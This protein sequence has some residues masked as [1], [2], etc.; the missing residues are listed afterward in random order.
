[1]IME[2][3]IVKQFSAF[4]EDWVPKEAS[5]AVAGGDKYISYV[6]GM[7]DIHIHHGQSIPS[8]SITEQVYASK[9]RIESLVDK[10]VF[11]LPYYGVG[12]P[13]EDKESGFTGA[14]TVIL[15][16]EYAQKPQ[17]PIS[18]IAGRV[19]DFWIPISVEDISYIESSRKKTLIYTAEGCFHS[20]HSLKILDQQLSNSFIRIHRSYI[21]HIAYIK[22]FTR[23]IASNLI[24]TLKQPESTELTVSQSYMKSVKEALGF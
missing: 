12:Y 3:T 4:L 24:V 7:H 16:P 13:I 1:M 23:D 10:S 9:Q 18:Y 21:V 19:N 8:G 15:P 14:I 20:K 5:I 2:S 22:H 11:G 6:P 17:Q